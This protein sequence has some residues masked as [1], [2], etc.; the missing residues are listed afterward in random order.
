MFK[1][2]D[3]FEESVISHGSD[4]EMLLI[5]TGH[6][7][8]ALRQKALAVRDLPEADRLLSACEA[9]W[10]AKREFRAENAPPPRPPRPRPTWLWKKKAPLDPVDPVRKQKADLSLFDDM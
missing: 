3:I 8:W 10:Q 6:R 2:G 4:P 1:K 7:I 5:R 9:V